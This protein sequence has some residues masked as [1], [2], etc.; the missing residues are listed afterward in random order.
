MDNIVKK[1]Q[2]AN[3]G[4][5]L[6]NEPLAKHTTIKIGGPA[7]I[8]IEP[9]SIESL[10]KTLEIIKEHGIKWRAIGRGSNLLV[11]DKGIEGAVIKLG[12]GINHLELKGTTLTV[13]AGYSVVSLAIQIAKK[14]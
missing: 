9:N 4:K 7:D 14:G 6:E 1:L 5:V 2:E 8:F 3:V 11:S 12:N 13:G 10:K